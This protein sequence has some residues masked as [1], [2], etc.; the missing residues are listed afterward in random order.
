MERGTDMEYV[1]SALWLVLESIALVLFASAFLPYRYQLVRSFLISLIICGIFLILQ[2]LSL[3]PFAR[4]LCAMAL[5]LCLVLCL[6]KGRWG[7]LL[8]IGLLDYIMIA[9]MDTIV[10]FG[11]SVVLQ[12]SL[13]DLVWRKGMYA[14][15]VTSG[16]LLSVFLAWLV[17]RL[18]PF[19]KTQ[20]LDAKWILLI[21][22]FPVTSLFM[23]IALFLICREQHDLSRPALLFCV[24]LGIAN[25]AIVYV[26][27]LIEHDTEMKQR[28][29][30]LSQQMEL[31]TASIL[32]LEK[33]YR[34]QRKSSHDFQ[35]HL[36]TISEL[37]DNESYEAATKYVHEL[38]QAQTNRIMI[39]NTH[40]PIIDAILNQ[41]YQMAVE[42]QI[43][44][45]FQFNDLSGV[46]LTASELVVL[47][48]NLLDNAIEACRR[49]ER[50]R[51]IL[52]TMLKSDSIFLSVRNTSLPV[53]ISARGIVTTKKPANEHGY[54]LSGVC[55]VLDSLHAEYTYDYENG[56]FQFTA[57]IPA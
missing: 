38:S 53:D 57:E 11:A 52:C 25:V 45:R 24:F 47:L 28:N 17:M 16:K 13:D 7:H 43:E 54:G 27:S 36:C 35:N 51:Q 10:V 2:S 14:V 33:A 6:F 4:R 39:V 12:I 9:V 15:L 19:H 50:D 55:R 1:I 30:M 18:H 56:W 37:L 31:Q 32:T 34:Q 40:H 49:M 21:S 22:I 23:M 41:K 20:R 8:F 48:S 5:S 46:T 3:P 42:S 26:V 29:N 44:M